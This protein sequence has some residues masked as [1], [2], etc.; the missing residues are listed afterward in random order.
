MQGQTNTKVV[1][2]PYPR[3]TIIIIIIIVIVESRH[4]IEINLNDSIFHNYDK[5]LDKPNR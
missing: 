3:D 2:L 5:D 4:N 1:T